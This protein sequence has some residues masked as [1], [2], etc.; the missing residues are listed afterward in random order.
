[1]VFRIAYYRDATAEGPHDLS[2]RNG[3]SR[4]IRS[5][6]MYIRLETS[7]DVLNSGFVK[8]GYQIDGGQCGNDL[9]TFIFRHER[10]P[11]TLESTRLPIRVYCDYEK[12]A[13]FLRSPQIANMAHVQQ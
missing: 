2:F 1:M 4:I 9:S 8:Y 10:A 7:N 12:I 5:F 13:E 11:R 6:C 3:V